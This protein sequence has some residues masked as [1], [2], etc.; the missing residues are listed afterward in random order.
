MPVDVEQHVAA[1]G[2]RRFDGLARGR[3]EIAVHLRPFEQGIGIA[4]PLELAQGNEAIVHAIDLA[5]A[6][7]ARRYTNRQA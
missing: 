3:I 5:A 2:H 7:G 4:Q 6:A 1:F